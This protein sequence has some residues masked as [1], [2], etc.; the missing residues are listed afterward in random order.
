MKKDRLYTANKWNKNLLF[1]GGDTS[2]KARWD[3]LASTQFSTN[4]GDKGFTLNDYMYG[5]TKEQGNHSLL[6]ISKANN[7]FSKGNIGNTLGNAASAAATVASPILAKAIGG[8]YSTGGVGEG[9]ATLGNQVGQAVGGP[10]GAVISVGSGIVGGGINRLFGTKWDEKLL[11]DIQENMYVGRSVGNALSKATTSEDYFRSAGQMTTGIDFDYHDLGSTGVLRSNRVLKNKARELQSGQDAALAAQRQGAML[12][13]I[14]VDRATDDLAL[15]NSRPYAFG[16]LLE[17]INN[18]NMGALEFG[19]AADY[20]NNYRRKTNNNN[21]STNMFAGMPASFFAEGGPK[22]SKMKKWMNTSLDDVFY[23]DNNTGTYGGGRGTGGGAGTKGWDIPEYE[24][25]ERNDTVFVPVETTF[26][27]AFARAR[28]SGLDTFNFNGKT[29]TTEMSDNPDWEVAGNARRE[30]DLVPVIT[31]R[32]TTERKKAFGGNLL[33]LG[34][35]Y[36][37]NGADWTTG[38]AHIDAGQSHELN[39]YE[40]VQV[41]VDSEGT[42][43]L[44][45]E[46]E[47][48][49]NDYVY[50]N[51]IKC[52]DQTKEKFRINKKRDITFADLSKK[53]EKESLER[54][55]DPI[56]TA[57]LKI[58]MEKLA[59]EQERQKAEMEAQR[60]KEAFE[61]LNPEE[62]ISVM[63]QLQA[64]EQ[65]AQ[66]AA[67]QEQAMAQQQTMQGQQVPPEM[68]QPAQEDMLAQEQLAQQQMTQQPVMAY[69]GRLFGKGGDID[70]TTLNWFKD[71]ITKRWPQFKDSKQLD[72]I[73]K[74]A[75]AYSVQNQSSISDEGLAKIMSYIFNGPTGVV[76]R[77][78]PETETQAT[79][80]R[81]HF[82]SL[83]ALGMPAEM[84][85]SIAFPAAQSDSQ[86]AVR[87]NLAQKLGISSTSGSAAAEAAPQNAENV[88]TPKGGTTS[89][90]APKT[91]ELQQPASAKQ[92]A[93]QAP[94]SKAATTRGTSGL[95][96]YGYYTNGSDGYSTPTGFKV[97]ANGRAYDY[98]NEYRDL[99]NRLGADDIRR[100]AAEHPND[101]SLKSFIARGNNLDTL[102]DEQ[103]KYGATDGKYGFMHHV[104]DQILNNPTPTEE[105]T[106]T[107]QFDIPETRIIGMSKP[108]I[109]EREIVEGV[110]AN[111]V[112]VIYDY[113]PIPEENRDPALG[114]TA[115]VAGEAAAPADAEAEKK[116]APILKNEKLRYAGLFGPAI[117]LGLMAAGVGKPKTKMYDAILEDFDTRG[118]ALADYKPIGNY[119]AYRPM[120]IWANQNRMNANARATDR[121]IINNSGPLGTQMAGLLA[122]NY[123]DQ[124]GS[125]ELYRQALEYNDNLRRQTA[126]FNKNTD[127]F[128][129]Q[130][131]NQAALTN[132]QLKNQS[133]NT[134]AQLALNAAYQ[135]AAAD[136]DWYNS[137]YGNIGSL[138]QGISDLGRENAE[139]NMLAKLGATGALG[140]L[141][142]IMKAGL[143][144]EVAKGGKIK[145]KK[146]NK[147]GLTF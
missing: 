134:R 122:S 6:H 10:W 101:V 60:A 81:R 102:T 88:E 121:A 140:N 91:Q 107:S 1:V 76:N 29:Y 22:G 147:R 58:Q 26:N 25:T 120:D 78:A 46:N 129:A 108:G 117:G 139:H 55:N 92:G 64:Q 8:G 50:S 109:D 94:P 42:P 125:G 82:D 11:N 136:S 13:A 52:D 7:P 79:I 14:G 5:T 137:L 32:K 66:E 44:V 41:G 56:S 9:V 141:S 2:D 75:Y 69:G 61:A 97:G 112:P 12:G 19:L 116:Y 138:F 31:K 113:T 89:T 38:L 51:R 111:G 28:R 49:F 24:T 20:V 65:A 80:N 87:N 131:Y 77:K 71:N 34:G 23:P 70:D 90:E 146:N 114:V 3:R 63:Q 40:G 37:T 106:D 47:T 123:N 86:K 85:F 48:I 53:L 54:P 67:M 144:K 36:Q 27:D 43:N 128:N 30:L 132:A 95:N 16:G 93:Q 33:A 103:W 135:K 104:A 15:A 96:L 62:Q 35:D 68:M 74:A 145:R 73:A 98:T 17:D 99:V 59:N 21:T 105:P 45:E 133:R 84:A 39:P 115:Q 124:L 4:Y 100:W 83:K 143:V 57:A 130:A 126:E 18:N 118:T 110:D 72:A 127:Q 142:D 119:L